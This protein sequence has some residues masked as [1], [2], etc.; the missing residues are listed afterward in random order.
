MW[1]IPELD[2]S[3]INPDEHSF[4]NTHFSEIKLSR[5]HQM[6]SVKSE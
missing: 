1:E 4:K 3:V 2:A 6:I 5:K